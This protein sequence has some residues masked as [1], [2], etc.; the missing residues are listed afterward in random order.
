MKRITVVGGGIT[1]LTILY[2]LQKWKL[3]SSSNIELTLVEKENKAGGK[4]RT[5]HHEDFIMETGADSV[6]ARHGAVLPLIEEAGL[7]EEMVYNSTGVSYLYVK[8]QLYPL[9]RDAVFGIPPGPKSLLKSPL[10]SWRG[11]WQAL[12]D[13]VKKNK[14]FTKESSVGE[15]LEAFLGRELVKNQIAPVLSGVYSGDIYSL[16]MASTL[17]YLVD[18]KNEFGSIMRGIAKNKETFGSGGSKKFISFRN[19][20][21]SLPE[22]L[23]SKLTGTEVLLGRCVNYIKQEEEAYQLQLDNGERLQADAVVIA[24]PHQT[25]SRIL[26]DEELTEMFNQFQSSS[27]LSVYAGFSL[28]PDSLPKDGTGFIVSEDSDLECNACTWSN[29]KWAHTSKGENVLVR[30]FYK[31]SKPAY[32][33]MQTGGE[34]QIKQTALKDL[35]KSLHIDQQP[36][37]LEVTNWEQLMPNYHIGHKSAVDQLER[38]LEEKY[39]GVYLAGASYYGVGIGACIQ[40]GIN[41][42]ETLYNNI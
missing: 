29:R 21:S 20:L 28:P 39:P 37:S 1:G 24:A 9:P 32:E 14:E 17:P 5:V 18:Y 12:G 36:T 6:V 23:L 7:E 33:R 10:L 30:L 15:F 40:N 16:T 4:I 38:M 2:Y 26:Q 8:D 41:T 11:K 13:Y 34:E 3:A 27:L 19:G 25:A 35:K 31:S 22:A 42:A